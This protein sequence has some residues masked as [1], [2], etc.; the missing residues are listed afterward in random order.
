MALESILSKPGSPGSPTGSGDLQIGLSSA[1]LGDMQRLNQIGG[2]PA[3][4]GNAAGLFGDA[5]AHAVNKLLMA[6]EILDSTVQVTT[7]GG[8]IADQIDQ[9]V[10]LEEIQKILESQVRRQEP[11]TSNIQER[12]F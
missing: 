10:S 11:G 12:G 3:A 9:G 8:F 6:N 2:L 4:F 7:I 1:S 5:S